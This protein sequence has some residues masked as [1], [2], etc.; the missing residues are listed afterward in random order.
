MLKRS[1]IALEM[2]CAAGLAVARCSKSAGLS[3]HRLYRSSV[4]PCA[5]TRFT[6]LDDML[7]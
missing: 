5:N 1:A 6:A 2:E 7:I 4:R 3:Q